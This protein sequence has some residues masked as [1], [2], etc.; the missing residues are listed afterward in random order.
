MFPLKSRNDAGPD[1]VVSPP[2]SQAAGYVVVV[3]VGLIIAF[4]TL[5]WFCSFLEDAAD[6]CITAMMFATKILRKT[7]GEDNRKTE[8]FVSVYCVQDVP[9]LIF[10]VHDCES[11]CQDWSDGFCGYLGKPAAR[12]KFSGDPRGRS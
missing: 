1:T 12:V 4:G 6:L 3:V 9:I 2:L 5:T 7:V 11:K 8:M 10:Q